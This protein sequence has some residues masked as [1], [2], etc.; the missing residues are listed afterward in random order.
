M[1]K[2]N[3]WKTVHGFPDYEVSDCGYVRNKKTLRILKPK[4]N[5]NEYLRLNLYLG[6]KCKTKLVHRLVAETFI[7][8]PDELKEVHHINHIRDDNRVENLMWVEHKEQFDENW[9]RGNKHA[10]RKPMKVEINGVV[11]ESQREA[12]RKTGIDLNEIRKKY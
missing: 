9:K 12:N 5:K 6:G 3:D 2:S 4:P 7:D 10:G 11:Y 8:N 1:N